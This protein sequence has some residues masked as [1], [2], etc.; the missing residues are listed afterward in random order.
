MVKRS[1]YVVSMVS[2]FHGLGIKG[3]GVS[4]VAGAMGG[5][6]G[7]ASGPPNLHAKRASSYSLPSQL[8]IKRWVS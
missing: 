7:A 1:Q 4:P 8:V 2:G 6:P 5:P 3:V